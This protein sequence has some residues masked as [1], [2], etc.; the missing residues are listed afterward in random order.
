[1]LEMWSDPEVTRFLNTQ[2]ISSE[3]CWGRLLRY[4]GHWSVMGYGYWAVEDQSTGAYVGE[5]GFANYRRN[6]KPHA[7]LAPEAGWVLASAHHGKGYA[8]EVA[9]AIVRWGMANF[10]D[11]PLRCIIHPEHTA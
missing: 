7:E 1:M 11:V 5:A 8:T 3:E 4:C 9:H 2:P 10:G 6:V